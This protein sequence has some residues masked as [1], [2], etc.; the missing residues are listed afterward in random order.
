MR[1]YDTLCD[2]DE[3]GPNVDIKLDL[4]FDSKVVT[5]GLNSERK[6]FI[7]KPNIVVLSESF[8]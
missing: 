6:P 5:A 4:I 7:E 1:Y 8:H 2:L 3:I